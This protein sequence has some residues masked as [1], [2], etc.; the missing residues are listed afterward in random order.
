MTASGLVRLELVSSKLKNAQ[1]LVKTRSP[2]LFSHVR[3][4][5][6]NLSLS[7][8]VKAKTNIKQSQRSHPIKSMVRNTWWTKSKWLTHFQRLPWKPSKM[9]ASDRRLK[10][11]LRSRKLN[12]A[13]LKKL[14]QARIF[15]PSQWK[16]TNSRNKT[17][18]QNIQSILRWYH[19]TKTPQTR[20]FL[21][22][23]G[24]LTTTMQSN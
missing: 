22:P 17:S 16:T 6:G 24:S 20:C 5:S 10:Y 14:H 15:K 23:S 18:H 4:M 21:I 9:F 8:R 11:L 12:W 7:K 13:R 2:H 3:K 19:R 1:I